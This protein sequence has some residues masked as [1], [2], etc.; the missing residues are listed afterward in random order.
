MNPAD[1]QLSAAHRVV[2]QRVRPVGFARVDS[3]RVQRRAVRV[4][5]VALLEEVLFADESARHLRDPR[6]RST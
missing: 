1:L 3:R 6:G 4:A 2:A 5:G